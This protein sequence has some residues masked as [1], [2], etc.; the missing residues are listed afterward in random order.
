MSVNNMLKDRRLSM[1]LTQKQLAEKAVVNRKYYQKLEKGKRSVM[2]AS[3]ETMCKI[4]KA[5]EIDITT[6]YFLCLTEE[7]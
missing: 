2:T 3:F 7:Q 6:F 5:L 4:L 1:G